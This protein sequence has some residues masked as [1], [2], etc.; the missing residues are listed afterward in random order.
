VQVSNR[1]RTG[2]AI[3][4]VLVCF[5]V[6]LQAQDRP[7]Q[8]LDKQYQ[9]AVSDYD[10]G[11]FEQ[12]A[13]EL[14]T[15]L[16]Y[17]TTSSTVHE[18]LG[19]VY[20]SLKQTDKALAQLK[21]A[22]QLKPDWAEA[23]TNFGTALLQADQT[24][25]AG[26]Q[27]RKAISLDPHGYDTNRNLGEFYA[28]TG[29]LAEALP[30]LQQAH[31]IIPAAYDNSYDLAMTEFLL[32]RNVDARALV[33]DLIKQKDAGELHSLLGQ[34]DEKEGKYLAAA[35]DYELAAHLDPSEDNLFD[36]GSE[37]LLHRTYEP[38]IAVFQEAA[39]RYPKSPRILIGLGLSLYSRGKYDEAVK[40]LLSAA[41]LNPSDPR[42]YVFLSKAYNSSPLQADDVLQAFHRYADLEPSSAL[43]QY[44]YAI[45]LWKGKRAEDA[46][47]DQKAIET[48]LLKSIALDDSLADAHV[49]LGN[50]YADR[51]EYQKSIPQ[52]VRAL[53]LDQNLADAHYRLGTDYVHVGQKDEA[54]KEFTVY[55]KLRA[56]HLNEVDKER[57]EVQQ[58]VYGA[59]SG[60][61]PQPD[62]AN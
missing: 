8:D 55:Q 40:A 31:A 30:L 44:Y 27:F 56:E 57:A 34:I 59:K 14:E 49:Q 10:A 15:V 37:M 41:D 35:A 62:H 16:P 2:V 5:A 50:L 38:A 33:L 6:P 23:R 18:L 19:L 54:Q 24:A 1:L 45:S 60:A 36:W 43:A 3:F 26:E 29:K 4:S 9:L 17:A 11:R 46:T 58:F 53:A 25:L 47:L 28:Q 13:S 12:A 51:H 22:V 32:G 20:A 7:K 52:Y 39:H 42:C 61:S 48:L 21:T